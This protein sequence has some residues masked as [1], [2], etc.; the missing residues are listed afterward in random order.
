MADQ[1]V[2][3][4]MVVHNDGRFRLSSSMVTTAAAL[5][6][7]IAL[8]FV[9][10]AGLFYTAFT[11]D[12]PYGPG[13][14]T[15]ANFI[16]TYADPQLLRLAWNSCLFAGAG[17]AVTVL[18]GGMVAW[19]VER[20][21]MPGRGVFH[22]LTLINFA[23]P[24]LLTSMA[25]TLAL[26]PR[27]GWLNHVAQG[28]LG[29]HQA[30][31][32]IYSI[33][34]MVWAMAAHYF[35]L[36][37]LLL[38]P[39]FRALDLRLEEA[40]TTSGARHWQVF[41]RVTLPLMRPVLLSTLLLLFLRGLESFE[42]PRI[43]G[44]PARI[45]TLTTMIADNVRQSPPAFGSASALS[46]LLL[47]ACIVLIYLYRRTIRRA[48][49]FASITGKGYKPVPLSL[50][51]WRWP[52]AAMIGLLFVVAVGV[53]LFTLAWQSLFQTMVQPFSGS[54]ARV[55][56]D[57]YRFVLQYPVF[58][59]AVRTS[60]TLGVMSAS[61]VVALTFLLAWIAQRSLPR[62]GWVL[63]TLASVPIAVPGIVIGV[64]VLFAYLILPIHVYD[65]IWI[66]LIAYCTLFL[67]YGMRFASGGLAQIHR[68]LEEAA[69]VS[70][71]SRAQ[72]FGRILLPLLA[73][74]IVSAWIYVF[75]LA[76][77]E[78]GASIML[79][80]PSTQVL[81]TVSLTMWE[82]GGSYG[83]VCALGI[84]QI[85]PLVVMVTLLRVL[86]RRVSR[87]AG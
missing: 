1:R 63:D 5:L 58:V 45:D 41:L 72:I 30:P 70:G 26:S 60:V 25:W 22:G 68:E 51:R 62:A 65:T 27:I 50:G 18:L 16:Q 4:S 53:P 80:G 48:E 19:A 42:V 55:T 9:P 7:L 67:P 14:A 6:V 47:A 73:P 12:T 8:V 23:L 44:L 59:Q 39:G 84:I 83:A 24:G 36:A 49:A 64:S 21:D 2:I 54:H 81:G 69:S 61:F 76:V 38:G 66:L 85:V 74:V 86:E 28:L 43:L 15:L 20:T 34:G 35:P 87:A 11:E 56:L 3:D 75:V 52:V 40:A 37:Y 82:E 33:G 78:L 71:A 32:N 46:M 77:R 10:L 17:A 13:A 31:I 79:I 57:N 29:L